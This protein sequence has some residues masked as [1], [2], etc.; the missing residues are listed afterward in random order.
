MKKLQGFTLIELLIVVAIIAIL[1]AIAVPNFMEAQ[2]RAKVTRCKNDMRTLALGCQS[3]AVD[4]NKHP[5]D[6]SDWQ[7]V[8]G[9]YEN[10]PLTVIT[11]PVAYLSTLLKD[12][13]ITYGQINPTNPIANIGGNFMYKAAHRELVVDSP[14]SWKGKLYARGYFFMLFSTGPSRNRESAQDPGKWIQPQGIILGVHGLEVYDSTN[15]TKSHGLIIRTNKNEYSG[16]DYV[17]KV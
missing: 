12:P 4:Y 1:A 7:D 9:V 13:F 6:A 10:E 2:V 16:A 5:Y 3:Y 14:N 11:T 15:G 8:T 17:P